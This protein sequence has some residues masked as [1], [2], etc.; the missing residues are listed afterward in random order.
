MNPQDFDVE[1][2]LLNDHVIIVDYY[3]AG[4]SSQ[5]AVVDRSRAN[6]S[7]HDGIA[8]THNNGVANSD[9]AVEV[10]DYNGANNENSGVNSSNG[11]GYENLAVVNSNGAS[12]ENPGVDDIIKTANDLT[13][14]DKDVE[15]KSSSR[16]V[17]KQTAPIQVGG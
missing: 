13:A 4:N 6:N 7:S 1:G 2:N 5:A 10:V 14:V 8:L 15:R 16:V 17:T 11:V 3:G 9:R 12:N